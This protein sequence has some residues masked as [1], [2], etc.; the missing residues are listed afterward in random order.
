MSYPSYQEAGLG[1]PKGRICFF[2]AVTFVGF[3][4]W[5]C[6]L[7]FSVASFA[8][9]SSN[10]CIATRN[11]C[12][13]SSNKKLVETRACGCFFFEGTSQC[14][15]LAQ[16]KREGCAANKCLEDCRGGLGEILPART[17][18]AAPGLTTRSK[19]LL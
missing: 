9:A 7:R 2:L 6:G 11:K 4:P 17:L 18:L 19:K 5:I 14:P 15:F 1:M 12:L 16:S 10:K 8:L 3:G 13:T